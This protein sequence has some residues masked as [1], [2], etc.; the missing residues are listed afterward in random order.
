M[1]PWTIALTLAL[2]VVMALAFG[3]CSL[4]DKEADQAKDGG[5]AMGSGAGE[6]ESN[7]ERTSG[8]EVVKGVDIDLPAGMPLPDGVQE[9]TDDSPLEGYSVFFTAHAP[10]RRF[11][12]VIVEMESTLPASGWSIV[13]DKADVAWVGDRLFSTENSGVEWNVY[14]RPGEGG[15]GTSVNYYQKE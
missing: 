10:G 15:H 13:E 1:R 2:V 9:V 8:D 5:H 14:V 4:G 7:G 6:A 12:D 11:N 3:A